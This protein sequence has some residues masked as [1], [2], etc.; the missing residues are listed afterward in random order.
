MSDIYSHKQTFHDY[1]DYTPTFSQHSERHKLNQI[2]R[3][4]IESNN[5]IK[6]DITCK[7][8]DFVGVTKACLDSHKSQHHQEATNMKSQEIVQ[9]FSA[10]QIT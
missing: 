6:I 10:E 8:C 7:M 4:T 9:V 1:S 5:L 3:R 2:E